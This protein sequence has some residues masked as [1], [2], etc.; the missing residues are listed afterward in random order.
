METEV[1]PVEDDQPEPQEELNPLHEDDD[2]VQDDDQDDP[3]NL[4]RK[5]LQADPNDTHGRDDHPPAE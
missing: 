3:S 1:T 2:S 4:S 5:S